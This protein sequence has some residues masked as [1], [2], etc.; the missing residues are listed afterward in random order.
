MNT[1]QNDFLE[2]RSKD[3]FYLNGERFFVFYN[4]NCKHDD[5]SLLSK[6]YFNI[7]ETE[8]GY[9]ITIEKYGG[10]VGIDIPVS[11][12]VIMG[13]QFFNV[14]NF[15]KNYYCYNKK[16]YDNF[17]NIFEEDY[18]EIYYPIFHNLLNE[19]EALSVSPA[20]DH[21]VI[22]NPHK[23]FNHYVRIQT[24]AHY[25]NDYVKFFL[26]K[27]C[28]YHLNFKRVNSSTKNVGL[29]RKSSIVEY[30]DILFNN[31]EVSGYDIEKTEEIKRKI[32]KFSRFTDKHLN[33][34]IVL[35]G[36]GSLWLN[37][38]IDLVPK[39]FEGIFGLKRDNN[40]HEFIVHI[41]NG[42]RKSDWL[43]EKN[44]REIS[45][46]D[47]YVQI[48]FEDINIKISFCR[49]WDGKRERIKEVDGVHALTPEAELERNVLE[50]QSYD[51]NQKSKKEYNK[52][53]QRISKIIWKLKINEEFG[54]DSIFNLIG[55]FSNNHFGDY[56]R[57]YYE[58]FNYGRFEKIK[59]DLL[60]DV[61]MGYTDVSVNRPFFI[62][63]YEGIH[64]YYFV[65]VNS[66]YKKDDCRIIL[67]DKFENFK[68]LGLENKN[69]DILKCE[70]Y[71]KH[72]EI[73][74]N[75][76]TFGGVLLASKK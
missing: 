19:N 43:S 16:N 11:S 12:E 42:L 38:Y 63:V 55:S 46:E 26:D 25:Q 34:K 5:V 72:M 75:N 31:L 2:V 74:V 70:K 68:W 20:S 7:N 18:T 8:I 21:E 17:Y 40:F 53:K 9:E 64:F 71:M 24:Y 54:E 27:S 10:Y 37:D 1:E 56:F 62:S 35:K 48:K 4:E 60:D 61:E 45:P 58:K 76:I 15:Q 59:N 36:Q 41:K 47:K 69:N 29:G 52:L 66:S 33:E 6:D 39:D 14:E 51:R 28:N 65:I 50:Y 23:R 44:I 57:N 22:I 3:K 13:N 32:Q 67:G 49:K 73:F 30:Q